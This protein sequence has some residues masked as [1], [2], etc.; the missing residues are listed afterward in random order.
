[1]TIATVSPRRATPA[2]WFSSP[3]WTK[4]FVHDDGWIYADGEAAPPYVVTGEDDLPTQ[5]ARVVEPVGR[6]F[7]AHLPPLLEFCGRFGLV[8]YTALA[9]PRLVGNLGTATAI[10]TRTKSRLRPNGKDGQLSIELRAGDSIHW[11]LRHATNV[12]LILALHRGTQGW[13]KLDPL[14]DQLGRTQ[15]PLTTPQ[16]K[17]GRTLWQ[18]PLKLDLPT[19]R[20]THTPFVVARQVLAA[21]LQPNVGAVDREIST[22]L[23]EPHFPFRLRA[24]IDAIYWQLADSVQGNVEVR[25]CQCGA[26]FFARDPRQQCC[27]KLPGQRESRCTKRFRMRSLRH[28]PSEENAHD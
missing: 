7:D 3:R 10:A 8:G 9:G 26:L 12:R 19:V 22:T 14:L 4:Y 16:S 23:G 20:Q 15:I 13:T 18:K 2:P 25:E 6:R 21:L 27:P 11:A 28:P 5:F 1:M 17:E 24:L